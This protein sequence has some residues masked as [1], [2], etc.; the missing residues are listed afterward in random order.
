MG[1]VAFLLGIFSL[2]VLYLSGRLFLRQTVYRDYEGRAPV[3][4]LF[5]AVFSLCSFMLEMLMMEIL[6]ILDPG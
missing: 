5:S 6:G 3:A 4:R 2:A 1:L